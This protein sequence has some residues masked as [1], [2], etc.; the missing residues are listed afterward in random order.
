MHRITIALV[1][2]LLLAACASKPAAPQD[3]AK[4]ALLKKHTELFTFMGLSQR[5]TD[6]L[7]AK[8]AWVYDGIKS[9]TEKNPEAAKALAAMVKRGN[10][11]TEQEALKRHG[12]RY[13]MLGLT[14]ETDRELSAAFSSI[15]R[16]LHSPNPSERAKK[17][18][19]L[20]AQLPPCCNDNIFERAGATP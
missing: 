5:S 12:D 19:E 7:L 11:K 13:K 2:G 14:P 20:M 17:I 16:D 3:P 9:K 8:V 4:E 10:P 6:E 1:F 15:Y 18:Q